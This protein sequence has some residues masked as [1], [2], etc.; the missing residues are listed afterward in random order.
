LEPQINQKL[1]LHSVDNYT[2]LI[3]EHKAIQ[4]VLIYANSP[5]YDALAEV[6]GVRKVTEET[7]PKELRSMDKKI[8]SF[9]PVYLISEEY[10]WLGMDYRAEKPSK[11]IT[12]IIGGAFADSRMRTQTLLRVGRFGDD[13]VIIQD[14]FFQ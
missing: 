12:L 9:F 14:E 6:E 3:K 4:S 5:L 1:L 2:K 11:G 13:C 10:G 8:D 7:D